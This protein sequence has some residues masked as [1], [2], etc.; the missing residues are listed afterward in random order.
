M[1]WVTPTSR[2]T[3]FLVTA[4]VWNQ[5]IVANTQYLKGQAGRVDTQDSMNVQGAAIWFGAAFGSGNSVKIV[6]AVSP[7][8]AQFTNE[9]Q[10]AFVPVQGLVSDLPES[11]TPTKI[12]VSDR[13]TPNDFSTTSSTFQDVTG[14]SIT[15][16]PPV[17][18]MIV[19][20]AQCSMFDVGAGGW[21]ARIMIDAEGG[22]GTNAAIG[23]VYK[24]NVSAGAR[25][26]K[27]Q[28]RS[29]D[30]VDTAWMTD[31]CLIAFFL[32][33]SAAA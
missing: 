23:L 9:G 27:L 13:S 7:V 3:G 32:P 6:H 33:Y 26:I 8:R 21:E 24:K 5:D 19:A 15:L 18:G 31:I 30:G 1:A 4:A 11:L 28:L 22:I 25:V 17:A 12:F 14:S 10:S 20:I 2:S 29:L 16:T